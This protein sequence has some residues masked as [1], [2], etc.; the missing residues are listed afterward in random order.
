MNIRKKLLLSFSIVLI[1]LAVISS[2][3]FYQLKAI[4]DSYSEAIEDRLKKISLTSDMV[5]SIYEQQI[6]MRGFL[7]SGA[8]T[9]I[10]HNI[11]AK[12][13]FKRSSDE[14]LQ[15]TRTSEIKTLINKIIV[16]ETQYQKVVDQLIILKNQ[17]KEKEYIELT[18]TKT[19]PI[20][21]DLNKHTNEL[22]TYQQNNLLD[23]SQQLS[24]ETEDTITLVLIISILAI[25][26]GVIIALWISQHISKPVQLLSKTTEQIANGNLVVE[27]IEVKN[28]DEIGQL[29][30]DFNQMAENLRNVIQQ[31]SLTSEQVAASAE[32]LTAS[33]EQTSSATNQITS[34]IE[35]VAKS[36]EALTINA[37]D[38]ANTVNEMSIGVQRVANTTSTVA[39]SALGTSQ[40]AQHGND[41]L[42]RV[43]KQMESIHS[44]T[45]ETNSI[46]KELNQRSSQIGEIIGVITDI[47]DQTNLLA[48]N[49]AIESARAGE[50]GRG[51]A[52]VADEVKKLAEQSSASAKQ[53]ADI[54]QAIQADTTQAV[55]MMNKNSLEV[56]DGMQLVEETGSAFTSILK[57]IEHVSSE[58]QEMSAISEEMS[59]SV[60][61]VSSSTA[62]VAEII[63]GTA[64]STTEIA[65]AS[66][67]QL[68]SMD[69]VSSSAA[70]LT[71]MSEEL[72]GIVR[73]F[74]I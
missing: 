4:N 41:S 71:K 16:Q 74:K 54:I 36:S 19:T 42:L 29:A 9:Q 18:R 28:K 52:V 25:I 30:D 59:A 49:A 44:S 35:G 10:D 2:I 15:I 6:A 61:Q 73:Q 40:Q 56:A 11:T 50:H 64:G 45:N 27:K 60:E 58:L 31:V 12:E 67:E 23:T 34:S 8:K 32:E 65:A 24:N 20:V 39:E 53:I 21:A 1:L 43:I 46:M 66:E 26:A 48:L 37:M 62:E 72:S 3:S 17:N 63:K 47:A 70:S 51:F 57:S 55:N 5:N 38:A 14:L 22:L 13:N 33:A 68:A 69:E 7:V